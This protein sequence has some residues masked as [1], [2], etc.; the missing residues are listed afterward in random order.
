[1]ISNIVEL[2]DRQTAVDRNARPGPEAHPRVT[3]Q[4][5]GSLGETHVLQVH[6]LAERR[7]SKA[8]VGDHVLAQLGRA[9]RASRGRRKYCREAE[10]LPGGRPKRATDVGRLPE[11]V[12]A[13]VRAMEIEL[14]PAD[15]N[16][17][18]G[19]DE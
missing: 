19:I 11:E 4:D 7:G 5:R 1:L 2:L 9:E 15:S 3:T 18:A 12:R 16:D 13:A 14:G 10:V 6:Q 8:K 17:G